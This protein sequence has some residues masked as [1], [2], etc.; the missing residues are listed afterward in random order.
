[1]DQKGSVVPMA[2]AALVLGVAAM[3]VALISVKQSR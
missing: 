2:A 1:M 3:V